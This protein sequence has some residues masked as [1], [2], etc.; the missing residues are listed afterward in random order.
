MGRRLALVA[1][2]YARRVKDHQEARM[3]FTDVAVVVAAEIGPVQN[4]SH[5][6]A[7]GQVHAAT[8]CESGFPSGRGVS[9]RVDRLPGG[10]HHHV[11]H[12]ERRTRHHGRTR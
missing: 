6:R 5:A 4:I 2:L 7:L 3:F 10:G 12:P 1:E 8:R 11:A 9:A